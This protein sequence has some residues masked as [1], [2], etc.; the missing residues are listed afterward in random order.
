V[1]ELRFEAGPDRLDA[2]LLR[3]VEA[4]LLYVLAHGAGADMRHPFLQ[5]IAEALAEL[6][7]AT[8]RFQFPY[9]QAG[10]RRP[11]EAAI[12]RGAVR[13]AVS[14]ASAAAPGLPV[15][16]GGKSMGGRMTTQAQ[17]E[18]PLTG[19]RGIALLGFPLH[20]ARRPATSR[21]E[22][23]ARVDSPLLFLQGSRDDLADLSLLRPIVSSLPRAQMRVIE[24]ADHS[25]HVLRRS[26]RTDPEVLDE[27]AAAIADWGTKLGTPY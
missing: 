12:L 16:A 8:F 4:R 2:L 26:G 13:A 9:T 19:V 5:R 3:P 21:A 24:G 18:A 17:A 6:Q 23:L 20:P 15:I 11:D 25:F 1:D 22:H 27:L 10:R 14:A 7:V